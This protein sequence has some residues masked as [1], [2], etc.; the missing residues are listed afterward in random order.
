[1]TPQ[2]ESQRLMRLS[3]DQ[4][5]DRCISCEHTIFA[6]AYFIKSVPPLL[7]GASI[8][9]GLPIPIFVCTKCGRPHEPKKDTL[10]EQKTII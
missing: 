5:N 1:M 7:S 3:A 8:P 2:E 6:K 9:L 4:P 10:N